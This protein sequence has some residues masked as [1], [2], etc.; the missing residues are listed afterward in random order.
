MDN[1]GRGRVKKDG[2][3]IN[4][5]VRMDVYTLLED[6]CDV[7]GQSKTTAIERAIESYCGTRLEAHA[8]DEAVV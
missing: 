3:C 4:A 6:Y 2:R 1:V 7:F 8:N 5:K